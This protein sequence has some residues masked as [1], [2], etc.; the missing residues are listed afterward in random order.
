MNW[1]NGRPDC[2]VNPHDFRN[3]DHVDNPYV[4]MECANSYE[5]GASAMLSAV[6][7]WL[8][9][10]CDKH[11]PQQPFDDEIHWLQTTETNMFL[12]WRHRKD[13][14]QCLNE[15]KEANK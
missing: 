11:T 15:L 9:E 7:K 14:P 2:W 4:E 5:A 6:I 12:R 8:D 10:P 1:I 13:C 3:P